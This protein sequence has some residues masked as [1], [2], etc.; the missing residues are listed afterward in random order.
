[1]QYLAM[2]DVLPWGENPE[3]LEKRGDKVWLRLFEKG[4]HTV[5]YEMDEKT[6]VMQNAGGDIFEAPLPY[7]SGFHYVQIFVEGR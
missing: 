3:P 4:A 1:M 6:Y 7:S 2:N 5:S